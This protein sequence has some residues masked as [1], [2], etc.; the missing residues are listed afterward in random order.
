MIANDVTVQSGSFGVL[1][2]DFFF[3]AS[4][5]ARE[6]G[7][8]HITTLTD[9]HLI[10]YHIRDN[11]PCY[12][13]H[14]CR[15]CTFTPIL[16]NSIFRSFL[17]LHVNAGI[18][19]VFISCN[20]GARIGLVDELKPKFKV[21]HDFRIDFSGPVS[22]IRTECALLLLSIPS[23]LSSP[24]TH[25]FPPPHLHTLPPFPT[26]PSPFTLHLSHYIPSFLPSSLPFILFFRWHGRKKAI[27]L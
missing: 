25:T 6:R 24:H 18:P 10:T 1:E 9:H 8:Y 19:R 21:R 7:T 22:C 14:F 3:K 4:V 16:I 26:H 2:D 20:S 11:C 27:P 12:A 13:R 23:L 15:L 5:Y 17:S